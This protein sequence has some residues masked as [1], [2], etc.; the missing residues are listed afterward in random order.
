MRLD[1]PIVDSG[2]ASEQFVMRRRIVTLI[3]GIFSSPLLLSYYDSLTR[4][5]RDYEVR[6]G[7]DSK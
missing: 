3:T 2:N 6:S 7:S 4:M 1:A 5:A